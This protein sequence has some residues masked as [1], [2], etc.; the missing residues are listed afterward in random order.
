MP[1]QTTLNTFLPSTIQRQGKA[2][3][4][5]TR[6][7]RRIF[8]KHQLRKVWWV[9]LRP[10]LERKKKMGPVRTADAPNWELEKEQSV[11][12]FENAPRLSVSFFLHPG[13]PE[14]E[15]LTQDYMKEWRSFSTSIYILP[16]TLKCLQQD[17]ERLKKPNFNPRENGIMLS[18]PQT[19]PSY[20]KGLGSP[21]DGVDL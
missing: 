19:C 13:F 21:R 5:G 10:F 12:T 11:T 14:V 17:P 6:G 20:K 9:P 1:K 4:Y 3:D 15:A 2:I 8:S 7:H 18:L 16:S